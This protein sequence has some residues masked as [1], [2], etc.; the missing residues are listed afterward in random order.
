M[1][2]VIKHL[3]DPAALLCKSSV[4]VGGKRP[5]DACKTGLFKPFIWQLWQAGMRKGAEKLLKTECGWLQRDVLPTHPPTP[6]TEVTDDITEMDEAGQSF[7]R[8]IT[9]QQIF[10]AAVME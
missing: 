5:P 7:F 4:E 10:S 1:Y 2:L 9:V 6:P 3:L 8:Q